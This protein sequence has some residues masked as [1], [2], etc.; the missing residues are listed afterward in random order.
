MSTFAT[1]VNH[2]LSTK[3]IQDKNCFYKLSK[4]LY[5]L[6]KF[7]S[8]ESFFS[9]PEFIKQVEA[10]FSIFTD[11]K[12]STTRLVES[13]KQKIKENSTTKNEAIR[14]IEQLR[15]IADE[16]SST[17]NDHLAT[18]AVLKEDGCCA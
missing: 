2:K 10:E 8:S 3:E 17:M 1:R 6:A 14:T 9:S 11:K 15:N 7:I 5:H 4:C 13:Y 12:K 18:M 16:Y